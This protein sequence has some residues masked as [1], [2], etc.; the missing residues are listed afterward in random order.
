[1]SARQLVAIALIIAGTLG[2][3]YRG[4]SFTQRT[5]EARVGPLEL[6]IAHHHRVDVPLWA[7]VVVI[8]VGVG[9]LV[10]HPRS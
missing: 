8:V 10:T 2:L 9:L 3:I 6:S 7:S 4:F 1:M 5:H